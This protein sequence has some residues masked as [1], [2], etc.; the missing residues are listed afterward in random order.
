MPVVGLLALTESA[1]VT[2]WRQFWSTMVLLVLVNSM[3][4]ASLFLVGVR[5]GG[6]AAMTMLSSVVPSVTALIAWPLLGQVP[7]TGAV[8]GLLLGFGAC[9]L[10]TATSSSSVARTAVE[11]PTIGG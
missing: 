11:E 7:T 4:G 5:N 6:A 10:G 1:G 2:D 8:S 9:R 3:G